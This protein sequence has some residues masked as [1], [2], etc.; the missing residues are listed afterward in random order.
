MIQPLS[1]NVNF[2]T[3]NTY[4]N[5]HTLHVLKVILLKSAKPKLTRKILGRDQ[6]ARLLKSYKLEKET[7]LGI[8]CSGLYRTAT[9]S[10]KMNA[11]VSVSGQP[12]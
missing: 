5:S 6:L 7:L 1:E 10:I 3:P 12:T 9:R 8:T 4:Y 11:F 2:T